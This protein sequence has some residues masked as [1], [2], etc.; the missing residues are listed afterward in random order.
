MKPQTQL[1]LRR[2][3][4]FRQS[5]ESD[6]S[7]FR[8]AF[9]LIE[10]L[11]VIAII[12]IIAAM[13][14]PALNKAKQ[15]ATA[16]ACLNNQKQL[17]LAW[18]MYAE[19]NGD[20]IVNLSTYCNPA[21]DF[22]NNTP[23]RQ[24]M[25][26]G[27]NN[28]CLVATV[29]AG[30]SAEQRLIFLTRMGYKQPRADVPGPLFKYAPAEDIMHCPGDMRFRRSAG[31]GFAWDSYSGA[32]F[33]NG[34]A[35]GGFKKR[36]QILHPS[37]RFLWVEGADGRGE[38]VGSWAMSNYG[39]AAAN[40]TDAKFRDSPAAFH[41]NAA[42]FSFSDGHSESHRWMDGTTIAYANDPSPTK[43]ASSA[44]QTAAQAGS[45]RDQQWVGSRY[46][47]PQNP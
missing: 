10:L 46:P 4:C 44:T 8:A 32:T 1:N 39:S 34:E 20:K 15:K 3:A 21:T 31:A 43:D 24:D 30:Y 40:Y 38:N 22:P 7:L 14:L 6:I 23:W 2:A 13:L 29:P 28:G 9:T 26:N 42:T 25:Y 27:L 33:L 36:G 18:I 11:V 12:A 37:G 35:S 41:V 47:G 5:Y 17:A 19:D 45:L 16:A